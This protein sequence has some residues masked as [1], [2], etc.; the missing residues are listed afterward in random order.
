MSEVE[1]EPREAMDYDVVVVGGGPSGLAAAI[2]LKQIDPGLS[3]VLVEKGSE[4]GAH[5][6]SGAVIDP[7]GLD[8]LLP[9]W[10]EDPACPLKV[11]VTDDHFYLLGPSGGLRLPNFLMPP[12]LNNHGN[13]VGSLGNVCRFLATKAEELGVEIY[14][15]FAATEV[16]YGD[17]GEVR[18]VATGDMGVGRDGKPKDSFTRGME[19]RGKYTLFAEGARGSLTKTLLASFGLDKGR[20]PQ[21]FG[22]GIKEI[23]QVDPAKHR[24]GVVH[25][26]FGWPLSSSTGGGSFLYHIE[27]NQV[28]VGFVVHLNYSESDSFALRRVPAFQDPSD[29]A[30]DLHRGQ[31]PR[32]W[33][34]RADRRRLAIRAEAGVP[35]RRA[36]RL[37]R[38][39][40][41]CPAHQRLA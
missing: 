27:D 30:R 18:G 39:L 33:R 28:V 24:P 20:E 5:I 22:L 23:W 34:P 36:R 26:S 15:G 35:R 29:G 25:H 12:L 17:K 10:R 16:I 6:L 14:P 11:Q 4:I 1:L 8:K 41:E 21:K 38:R 40:H 37:R 32:L 7:V 13:F 31:A 3:V 2:R 9:G 19:L